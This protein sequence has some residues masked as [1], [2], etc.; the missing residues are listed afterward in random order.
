[1]CRRKRVRAAIRNEGNK[2]RLISSDFEDTEN[3]GRDNTRG[4]KCL[5]KILLLYL[6]IFGSTKHATHCVSII[7]C[8]F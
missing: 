6:I 1:M 7:M 4:Q 3:R 8:Y 2:N 5:G